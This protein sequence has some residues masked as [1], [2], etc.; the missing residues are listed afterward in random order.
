MSSI[1]CTFPSCRLYQ[2]RSS[3]SILAH[4]TLSNAEWSEP[5]VVYTVSLQRVTVRQTL[6]SNAGHSR[7]FPD[8]PVKNRLK[9]TTQISILKM[10]TFIHTCQH[11]CLSWESAYFETILPTLFSFVSRETEYVARPW[12]IIT[13]GST[14]FIWLS[15]ISHVAWSSVNIYTQYVQ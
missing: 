15:D 9:G 1:I 7:C 6:R 12:T 2:T 3:A 10:W 13:Q 14:C 8:V 11:A 5:C 4:D